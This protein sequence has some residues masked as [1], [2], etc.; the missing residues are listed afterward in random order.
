VRGAGANR[1][2]DAGH[3]LLIPDSDEV[4]QLV[5]QGAIVGYFVGFMT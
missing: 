2:D 3:R 4:Q 1:G 5:D